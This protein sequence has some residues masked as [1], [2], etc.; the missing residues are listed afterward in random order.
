MLEVVVDLDVIGIAL[1]AWAIF[2]EGFLL[3]AGFTT[4]AAV[5]EAVVANDRFRC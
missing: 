3:E 4:T 5:T 1:S 2:E